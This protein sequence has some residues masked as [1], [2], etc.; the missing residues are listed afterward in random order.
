M[1]KGGNGGGGGGGGGVLKGTKGS[2]DLVGSAVKDVITAYA[3]DDTL[4]GLAGNDSMDGGAGID[5]AVFS[6]NKTDYTFQTLAGGLFQVSGPD[7]VDNLTNIEFLKFGADTWTIN[8]TQVNDAPVVSGVVTGTATEDGA[9]VALDALANASDVDTGTTLSVVNVPITLPAGVSYDAAAHSFVLD[10][11]DAAFQSLSTGE[12]TTVSVSYGVSDG[13]AT[14]N[15]SVSWT[16][17]GQDDGPPPPVIHTETLFSRDDRVWFDDDTLDF[18]HSLAEGGTEEFYVIRLA[19]NDVGGRNETSAAQLNPDDYFLPGAD[20]GY[21]EGSS[22]AGGYFSV[23]T[24]EIYH[25][26]A[27]KAAF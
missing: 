26:D 11:S 19:N 17:A 12:E 23:G 6:G 15:A 24:E 13:T 20:G 1:A 4:T 8:L 10:P 9:T 5:T 25:T 21:W 2:D 27:G 18:S 22:P 7:G 3:G 16:V 14:T